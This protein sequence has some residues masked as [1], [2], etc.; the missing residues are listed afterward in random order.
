MQTIITLKVTG[1][2]VMQVTG[3]I[4]GGGF[5]MIITIKTLPG[6]RQLIGT[7]DTVATL[8]ATL[9]EDEIQNDSQ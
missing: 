2:C 5:L 7:E 9:Q 1:V 3:L 6:T 4:N 8:A